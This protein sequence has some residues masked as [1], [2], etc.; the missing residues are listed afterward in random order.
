MSDNAVLPEKVREALAKGP[1][2]IAHDNSRVL[3][4]EEHEAFA[5]RIVLLAVRETEKRVARECAAICQKEWQG[6]NALYKSQVAGELM[7]A[8]LSRY[9]LDKKAKR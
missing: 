9:G 2:T 4:Y 7:R 6:A 3:S 1:D 8:I 5:T